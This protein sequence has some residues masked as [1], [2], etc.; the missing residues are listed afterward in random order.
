VFDSA[1]AQVDSLDFA[2]GAALAHCLGAGRGKP[3]SVMFRS[4]IAAGFIA[5]LNAGHKRIS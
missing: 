4:S 3:L 5:E 2:G 1:Q